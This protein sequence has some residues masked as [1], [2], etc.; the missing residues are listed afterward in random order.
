MIGST[1]HRPDVPKQF[2]KALTRRELGAHTFS[3]TGA[4]AHRSA[5][6]RGGAGQGGHTSHTRGRGGGVPVS[7]S[8]FPR[9]Y[10]GFGLLAL[11]SCAD[12]SASTL[13]GPSA[14]TASSI[15]APSYA[16]FRHN[17][18]KTASFR[19][20]HRSA[21]RRTLPGTKKNR[22]PLPWTREP[23]GKRHHGLTYKFEIA[24]SRQGISTD[25]LDDIGTRS[26]RRRHRH[27]QKATAAD[28]HHVRNSG[29]NNYSNGR[30]KA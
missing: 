4:A 20:T 1:S 21:N 18:L 12:S 6:R 15:L 17:C 25:R 2:L 23:N 10:K 28:C 19:R 11:H 3:M 22:L 13:P 30:L 24:P 27:L 8:E 16:T 7:F 26:S 5:R 14:I 9:R 29:C